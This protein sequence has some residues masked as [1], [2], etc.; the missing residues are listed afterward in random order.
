M[1]RLCLFLVMSCVLVLGGVSF[2]APTPALA[3]CGINL[4]PDAT[5][6]QSYST[7]VTSTSTGAGFTCKVVAYD[8]V[9]STTLPFPYSFNPGTAMFSCNPP[10]GSAGHYTICFQCQEYDASAH[11]YPP[12]ACGG[13]CWPAGHTQCQKCTTLTVNPASTGGTIPPII[14][15]TPSPTTTTPTVTTFNYTIGIESG[16]TLNTASVAVNGTN[17]ANLAGGESRNFEGTK[18]NNYNVSVPSTIEGN[19]G[20]RFVIQGSAVKTVNFENPNA[21]FNYTA[22]YYIEFKTDPIN[23]AQLPGSNW[24]SKGMQ[25]TSSAPELVKSGEN[26]EYVFAHWNLLGGGTSLSRDLAVTANNAGSYIAVYSSQPIATPT[27]NNTFMWII[28]LVIV[29]VAAGT[30]IAILTRRGSQ[31]EKKRK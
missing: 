1:S 13:P 15:Y 22:E 8:A 2:I 6:G 4:F 29:V 3:T 5:E 25:A 21:S 18:G 31:P 12:T 23:V 9:Y 26:N 24:Y 19:S 17:V 27:Q 7:L 28:I 10:I 30:A 14:I 20:T 16:L 11:C